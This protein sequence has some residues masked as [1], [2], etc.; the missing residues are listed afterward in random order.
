MIINLLQQSLLRWLAISDFWVNALL[1][2]LI[3]VA[4]TI[5]AVIISRLRDIWTR[6][7]LE[8]RPENETTPVKEEDRHAG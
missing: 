1:G 5:E 6:R 7:G 4:V 3:L 8:S 2:L